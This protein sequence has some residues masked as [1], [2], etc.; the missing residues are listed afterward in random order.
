[1]SSALTKPEVNGIL[2]KGYKRIMNTKKRGLRLNLIPA[3]ILLRTSQHKENHIG[4]YV[5]TAS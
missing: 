1:M 5:K 3:F 4:I 2:P